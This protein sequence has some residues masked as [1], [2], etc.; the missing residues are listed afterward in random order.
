MPGLLVPSVI[1]AVVR[2]AKVNVA[3]SALVGTRVS[4]TLPRKGLTYPWLQVKRITG[5]PLYKNMP[6]DK[7]RVQ[8]NAWGGLKSNDLPDWEPADLLIRT[9]EAEIREFTGFNTV[10]AHIAEMSSLSGI[11]QLEDPD[12]QEAKFWMDAAVLV[13]RADGR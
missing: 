11:M 6:M 4:S 7:A 10:E 8:F 9:L 1:E 3:I 2:W 12:T 5:L 13:R